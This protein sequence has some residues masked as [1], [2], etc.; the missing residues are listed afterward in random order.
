MGWARAQSLTRRAENISKCHVHTGCCGPGQ[1]CVH[2]VT[3]SGRRGWGRAACARADGQVGVTVSTR[4]HRRAQA[5]STEPQH[6]ARPP[7]LP[8]TQQE[9]P[10]C[11]RVRIE[12]AL[13]KNEGPSWSLSGAQCRLVPLV[14]G[15]SS[16][17]AVSMGEAEAPMAPCVTSG[18]ARAVRD[19]ACGDSWHNL[20]IIPEP[21]RTFHCFPTGEIKTQYHGLGP[22]PGLPHIQ[23]RQGRVP[24]PWHGSGFPHSRAGSSHRSFPCKWTGHTAAFPPTLVLKRDFAPVAPGPR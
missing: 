18:Q 11:P 13:Q 3:L 14:G 5:V 1:T 2:G 10:G 19:Q 7:A 6:R 24:W 21:S 9:S 20:L 23:G 15:G 22:A 12:L 8:E 16:V 4:G 17:R